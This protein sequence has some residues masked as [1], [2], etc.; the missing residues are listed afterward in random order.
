MSGTYE[1]TISAH[2]SYASSTADETSTFRIILVDPCETASLDLDAAMSIF[3]DPMLTYF[4][5]DSAGSV[6][7]T[8]SDVTESVTGLCGTLVYAI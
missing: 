3:I 4:V 1:F 5:G 6:S 7:W 2:A 8:D